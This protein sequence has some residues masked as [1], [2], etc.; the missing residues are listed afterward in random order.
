M[1]P[2]LIVLRSFWLNDLPEI[3]N[4]ADNERVSPKLRDHW[5]RVLQEW[6]TSGQNPSNLEQRRQKFAN[7]QGGNPIA[8]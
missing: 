2:T 7:R 5:A 4:H 1:D 3:A 6:R 8:T